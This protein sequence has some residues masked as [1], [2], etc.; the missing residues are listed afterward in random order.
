VGGGF[1]FGLNAPHHGIKQMIF[2][3]AVYPMDDGYMIFTGCVYNDASSRFSHQNGTSRD[4]TKSQSI[5]LLPSS[6]FPL[7]SKHIQANR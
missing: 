3:P 4:Q 7:K 5:T 6:S 1:G 2:P